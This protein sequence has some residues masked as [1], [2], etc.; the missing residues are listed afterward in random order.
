MGQY[1]GLRSTKVAV[2]DRLPPQ[3][4]SDTQSGEMRIII[5]WDGQARLWQR[6]M[7]GRHSPTIS[8]IKLYATC[9]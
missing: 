7:D 9:T 4:P 1:E 8:N 2:A 6:P 3:Y 5:S